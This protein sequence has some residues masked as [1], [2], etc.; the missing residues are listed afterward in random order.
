MYESLENANHLPLSLQSIIKWKISDLEMGREQICLD[1]PSASLSFLSS[2]CPLSVALSPTSPT[3]LRFL[4][5]LSSFMDQESYLSRLD[6]VPLFLEQTIALLRSGMKSGNTLPLIATDSITQHLLE[7]SNGDSPT[8]PLF[9]LRAP[10]LAP[11]VKEEK[12]I[13]E[14]VAPAYATLLDFWTDEYLPLCQVNLGPTSSSGRERYVTLLDHYLAPTKGE[15]TELLHQGIVQMESIAKKVV[16]QLHSHQFTSS[17]ESPVNSDDD[18]VRS[19]G[20]DPTLFLNLQQ[21]L[22][23]ARE[24]AHQHHFLSLE[25]A[26]DDARYWQQ[27]IDSHILQVLP[28]SIGC[29]V[30]IQS[31]NSSSQPFVSYLPSNLLCSRPAL[32]LINAKNITHRSRRS[33]LPHLLS[34]T[35]GRHLLSSSQIETLGPIQALSAPPTLSEGWSLYSVRLGGEKKLFVGEEGLEGGEEADFLS[36]LLLLDADMVGSI[37]MVSDI[38]VHHLG[39]EKSR[40]VEMF[41]RWSLLDRLDIEKEVEMIGLHPAHGVAR[42]VGDHL[43]RMAREEWCNEESPHCD[44]TG[45]HSDVMGEGATIF[46]P[47]LS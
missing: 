33:L 42:G 8:H 44:L 20:L 21:A 2:S 32:I 26:L 17:L 12:L 11:Q 24:L 5:L 19:L 10:G 4:P 35:P 15:P 27:I 23:S 30:Q 18:F 25:Q 43:L 9:Q 16:A 38:G 1:P 34:V 47:S 41:S 40:V 22:P 45:F 46:F 7:M 6:S 14:K 39:W 36:S 29:P 3:S 28:K 31:A 13:K 37:R